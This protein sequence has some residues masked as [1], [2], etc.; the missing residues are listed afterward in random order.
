M[1]YFLCRIVDSVLTPF[2]SCVHT[3]IFNY[4]CHLPMIMFLAKIILASMKARRL[5]VTA[6]H[7]RTLAAIT[8]RGRTTPSR[9]I[10][11]P[12]NIFVIIIIL[13][14]FFP[15]AENKAKVT[16]HSLS[17]IWSKT[18]CGIESHWSEIFLPHQWIFFEFQD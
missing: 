4:F 10:F 13:F 7:D 6:F 9:A 16:L 3:Y 18:P 12:I 1:P 8:P 2:L 11:I 17:Q 15:R 14:F 5:R